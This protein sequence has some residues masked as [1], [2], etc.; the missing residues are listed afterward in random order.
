MSL[1]PEFEIVSK[2]KDIV[3]RYKYFVDSL[4]IKKHDVEKMLKNMDNNFFIEC[5]Y[6]LEEFNKKMEEI[7]KSTQK[8]QKLSEEISDEIENMCKCHEYISDTIDIDVEKTAEIVYCKHC[9]VSKKGATATPKC[10]MNDIAII[11]TTTVHV[12]GSKAHIFQKNPMERVNIYLKSIRQWLE[13]TD[14]KIIVVEN[15]GYPFD[16]LKELLEKY[17]HRFDVVKYNESE[18][19]ESFF[20]QHL[21]KCLFIKTDYLYTSK[22]ASELLAINHAKTSSRLIKNASYIFKVTGRYFIPTLQHYL[23]KEINIYAYNAFRQNNSHRC[24]ILGVHKNYYDD[25]FVVNGMYCKKCALYH[26][27]SEDLLEH[28]ISFIPENKINSFPVFQIEPTKS[29]ANYTFDTL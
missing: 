23:T 26:H 19:D 27:H 4:Q 6:I 10:I 15:S 24:E 21:A 13:K 18:K 20:Q 17:S 1:N 11:L 7:Q 14:F 12:N 9:H 29:G 5:P 25:V 8:I 22:G 3:D 28:R 2:M 16:E